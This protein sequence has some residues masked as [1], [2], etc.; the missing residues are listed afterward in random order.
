MSWLIVLFAGLL[1]VA[2]AVGL[3]YTDGFSKPLPSILTLLAMAGSFYL[4][5]IAM[6][7]L[8]LGT[9]YAVWVGIGIIGTA[10]FGIIILKEP[11]SVVKVLSIILIA[12]GVFGLSR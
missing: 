7:S 5:S 10:L 1:E 6:K 3:K 12:L 9:A 4:L 8:P 11:L 2:W